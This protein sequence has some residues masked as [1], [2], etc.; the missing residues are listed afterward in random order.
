MLWSIHFPIPRFSRLDGKIPRLTRREVTARMPGR[1]QNPEEITIHA[2]GSCDGNPG[3]GH[4]DKERCD[5]LA[6]TEIVKLCHN[7]SLEKPGAIR[8]AFVASSNP[9]RK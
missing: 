2:D 1:R 8:E 7:S 5:Q 3:P 6:G 9:S 4:P